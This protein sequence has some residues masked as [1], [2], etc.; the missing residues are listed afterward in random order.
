MMP[1][2][3]RT[4]LMTV[5][6]PS[7]GEEMAGRLVEER[8]AACGSVIPAVV[9]VYRWEGRLH[10]D[11]EALVIFKTTAGRVAALVE[12]AAE[13]HPYDVPEILAVPVLT[14]YRPY[15]DWVEDESRG[16]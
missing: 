6:D 2:E 7:T 12:R 9:S 15:M 14:G 3:I 8:L 13:I 1:E 10:K 5:P 16:S 4:V 11:A